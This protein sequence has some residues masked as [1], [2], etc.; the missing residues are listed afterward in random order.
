VGRLRQVLQEVVWLAASQGAV[1][2]SQS[3][4]NGRGTSDAPTNSGT[5]GTQASS[6]GRSRPCPF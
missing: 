5:T 1:S 2:G 4:R 3:S 6:F